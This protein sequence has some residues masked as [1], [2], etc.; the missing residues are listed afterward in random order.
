MISALLLLAA[1]QGAAD[2]APSLLPPREQPLTVAEAS[3][4]KRS[5]RLDEVLAFVEALGALPHGDR[6]TVR[7]IGRTSEGRPLVAVTAALTEAPGA[8]AGQ[9]ANVVVNANIHGGEI[10]GKAA[11]QLLLRSIAMGR[12]EDVLERIN[13]TFVPVYNADGNDKISRR[14]R[15]TQNGPDGGVGQRPN[16]MG[17]DLNRDFVKCEAPET[18]ALLG[19]VNELQPI[20]FMD[21]HTTN[22]SA[23]GYD[24]T[25]APSLTP[26]ARKD[27]LDATNAL[28]ARVRTTLEERDG[29][30][31]FD[32][33][34]FRYARREPGSRGR[35]G[36]PIA[37]DTYDARSRFGTNMMG[38][39][40]IVSILS[41]AYSY[42]PYERRIEATH[43]FTLECLREI[44]RGR[45]ELEEVILS[46]A[47]ETT[48]GLDLELGPIERLSIRVGEIGSVIIDVD[49][50]E[51]GVQEGRRRLASP[52]AEARLVEMDVAR[53]FQAKGED[54]IGAAWVLRRPTEEQL[55]LLELHLGAPPRRLAEAVKAPVAAFFVDEVDRAERPFQGH[56]VVSVKG[57]FQTMELGLPAGAAVIPSSVLVTQLLHPQSDDSFTTWNLFDDELR[58]DK[59]ARPGFNAV[60]PS[61]RLD[62]LPD[63]W[64]YR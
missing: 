48:F 38:V 2:D 62:E 46:P 56:R 14:E 35:R 34:N 10:E 60:H 27:V 21:L 59:P 12:H 9:R 1:A 17:L 31:T 18:R 7:T 29:V 50:V 26:N 53:R 52:R 47:T 63:G 11:C 3:G 30:Y 22:G 23:H 16:G 19:L 39:R 57:S 25:Y 54:T 8:D 13:V 61:I 5:S 15:I 43:A 33:G 40:G 6:L 41:E 24:L 44:A 42:L 64:R 20:A 45:D 58:I 55:A 51:P 37:W 28:L 49:P 32:Y 36:D 4:F